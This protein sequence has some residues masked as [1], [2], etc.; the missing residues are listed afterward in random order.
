MATGCGA[1]LIHYSTHYVFD[2]T[3]E[4]VKQAENSLD[5]QLKIKAIKAIPTSD[6]PTPAKRP[7]NSQLVLTKLES[8]FAIKVPEWSRLLQL[9]LD[10][11]GFK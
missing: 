9:C 2:G 11:L 6:Y 5:L 3:E 10:D 4:I 7:M 8:G 1:L